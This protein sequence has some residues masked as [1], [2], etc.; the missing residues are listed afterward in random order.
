[1]TFGIYGLKNII[2]KS[3]KRYLRGS[4][5]RTGIIYK[6]VRYSVFAGG[7]RV[8]P[9]LVLLAGRACGLPDA[10]VMPAACAIEM[11]HTYSLI[12]DDL[13][14][15][16]NDDFRR[17][18][19]TSHRKFGE[20]NAI[21]AGDALLTKAFETMMLCGCEPQNLIKAA[22]KLAGAA[23]IAG[24]VGGQA[25]DMLFEGKKVSKAQ[26]ALIHRKKT[27]AMLSACVEVPAILAGASGRQLALWSAFGDRIGLAFQIADD[28]LDATADSKK[29]GKTAGK[30]AKSGKATYPKLYG[31]EI[32][33]EKLAHLTYEAKKILGMM[34]KNTAALAEFTDLLAGRTF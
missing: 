32:S 10:A 19:P 21:L 24:M 14:A 18:K 29:L 2:D 33:R 15:M 23:G 30:D 31:L 12:H 4:G 17:G 20:A 7:K 9:I 1:M 34:H 26:L 16:D 5:G 3:L 13:P 28:I 22:M 11:I 8:R 6:A 25:A 27:G